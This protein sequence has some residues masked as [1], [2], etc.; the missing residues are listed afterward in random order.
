MRAPGQANSSDEGSRASL[1][2]GAVRD[3]AVCAFAQRAV[4][5]SVDCLATASAGSNS[6]VRQGFSS[7]L[8]TRASG[9]GAS[10]PVRRSLSAPA[11]PAGRP[12][13]QAS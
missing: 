7:A 12:D 1:S 3:Q 10:A 13:N 11:Q 4:F 5:A 2:A 9:D 8:P 6:A